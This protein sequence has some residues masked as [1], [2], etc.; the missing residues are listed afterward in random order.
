MQTDNIDLAQQPHIPALVP[1]DGEEAS[2]EF[3]EFQK[4]FDTARLDV[5]L[6]E[7][8]ITNVNNAGHDQGRVQELVNYARKQQEYNDRLYNILV[9][10]YNLFNSKV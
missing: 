1:D 7:S 9:L 3:T 8:L 6:L 10:M 4:E 5:E 2:D